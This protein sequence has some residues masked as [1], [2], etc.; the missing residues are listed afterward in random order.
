MTLVS[1]WLTSPLDSK[2]NIESGGTEMNIDAYFVSESVFDQ[3]ELTF[4]LARLSFA[5][6]LSLCVSVHLSVYQR[7]FETLLCVL[8]IEIWIVKAGP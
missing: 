5:S 7:R 1:S 8:T 6:M 2:G 3:Q 4:A